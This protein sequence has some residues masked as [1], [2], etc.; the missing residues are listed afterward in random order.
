MRPMNPGDAQGPSRAVADP[1]APGAWASLARWAYGA[2][3]VLATPL[4]VARLWWRGR[5][6]P[7]YRTAVAERLGWYG[8]A[9]SAGWLWIHAVSLGETRAAA[10]LVNALRE[11][12][13]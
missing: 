11:L 9:P 10:A 12:Q 3:L 4:Y 7:L 13:P 6:E 5:R 1:K 8:D 2:V